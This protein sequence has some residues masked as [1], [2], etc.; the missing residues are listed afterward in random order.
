L[1]FAKL[2]PFNA[3]IVQN[4]Y[5]FLQYKVHLVVLDLSA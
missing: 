3:A 5:N 2:Q 4:A 1:E